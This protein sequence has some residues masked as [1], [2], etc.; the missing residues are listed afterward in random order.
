[1]QKEV[2]VGQRFSGR[3][4]LLVVLALFASL[5]S[6]M[7]TRPALGG[8]PPV[9]LTTASSGAEVAA[10][11]SAALRA[12]QTARLTARLPDEHRTAI[13]YVAPASATLHEWDEADRPLREFVITPAVGFVRQ[14]DPP[15]CW[16]SSTSSSFLAQAQIFEPMLVVLATSEA[17]P[18]APGRE[19]E[20][21][22]ADGQPA[23][24][25]RYTHTDYAAL[26]A[27]GLERSSPTRLEV[28]VDP[29]TALP[30]RTREEVGGNVT[31][32][33]YVDFNEPLTIQ[34]PATDR[35]GTC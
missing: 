28:V 14:L 2:Q 32:V 5:S 24:R 26:R 8:Q 35:D 17:L 16:R 19:V 27:I 13:V 6:F 12:V 15:E 10:R 23:L 29:T 34:P 31:E 22:T 25:A 11:L 4:P 30:Y 3:A 18:L 7:G 1:V 21:V 20:A 9:G 33:T